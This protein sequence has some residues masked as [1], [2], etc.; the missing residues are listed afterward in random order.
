MIKSNGDIDTIT[1]ARSLASNYKN[2]VLN[3]TVYAV[4]NSDGEAT[5]LYVQK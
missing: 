3:A 4:L 2:T 5:T 1:S